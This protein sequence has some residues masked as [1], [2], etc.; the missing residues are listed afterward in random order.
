MKWSSGTSPA[1]S[2]LKMRCV[3]ANTGQPIGWGRM[4]LRDFVGGIVQGI[5]SIITLIV[6]FVMFLTG[7]RNQ[8]IPDKIGTTVV[9]YDPNGV[10][11]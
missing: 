1:L 7:E 8:T 11:G 3:D 6:S 5:L 9:V 10:L 4:F 2:V